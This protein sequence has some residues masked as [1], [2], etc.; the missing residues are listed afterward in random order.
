MKL[1]IYD[2]TYK[3]EKDHPFQRH[4]KIYL[5]IGSD[6]NSLI[7]E[8]KNPH[9]NDRFQNRT[10]HFLVDL[11]LDIRRVRQ[12]IYSGVIKLHNYIINMK[13]IHC[14]TIET[15]TGLLWQSDFEF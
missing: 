6:P 11:Y 13:R 5:Y 12:A 7:S 1:E 15:I 10:Q 14:W 2:P 9:I 4:A 3:A 8:I